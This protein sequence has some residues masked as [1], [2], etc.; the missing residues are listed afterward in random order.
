MSVKT[1]VIVCY[2]FFLLLALGLLSAGVF[3]I[4]KDNK[5]T[6]SVVNQELTEYLTGGKGRPTGLIHYSS[7]TAIL[8]IILTLAGS[9]SVLYTGFVL[10]AAVT[11]NVFLICPSCLADM[12]KVEE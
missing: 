4:D 2:S 9:T 1:G 8:G 7:W 6:H 5:D 3:L 12:I 10:V 11:D